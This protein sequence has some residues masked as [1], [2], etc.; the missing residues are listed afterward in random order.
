M[1]TLI[2][3]R[4]GETVGNSSVRY[5]GRTDVALSHLGRL[6]MRA[7]RQWLGTEFELTRFAPVIS[8]PL[9][10]AAE[11][12]AIVAGTAV[13]II[14][15]KEFVEVDF[16]R[17][18]GL[19]ADEIR[20]EY[21]TDFERWNRD[22]L[23]PAFTYPGGESRRAFTQRVERGIKRMLELIDCPA[24]S[25]PT[26]THSSAGGDAGLVVAHRGVIRIIADRLAR[27]EP[28][29]ELGSIH[30]LQRASAP[31][32]WQTKAIDIVE[33]LATVG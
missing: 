28:Q 4:H 15:I 3:L 21:P 20:A 30:I 14:E 17:F 13:P 16:G 11:G 8:S 29:I 7:A 33:H 9:Q 26:A 10:R 32:P 31:G 1:R 25:T 19:T 22:R 5:H 23:D 12:A 18:E 2:L 24:S 6:Q 27:V